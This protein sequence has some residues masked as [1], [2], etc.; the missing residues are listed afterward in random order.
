MRFC[1]ANPCFTRK[2]A[3]LAA[4]V[5]LSILL[6]SIPADAA[7]VSGVPAARTQRVGDH[8]AYVAVASG[9]SPT[10]WQWQLDGTNLPG[11]TASSLSLTNI[12]L[13]N[14]GTYTV[15]ATVTGG[16]DTATATLVVSNGYLPL[17]STNLVVARLGDGAQA[18]NTTT[19]NT[20][21]L[22]Q[23]Q[24]NGAYVS[25]VMVP[26]SGAS[27]MI[28]EGSGSAGLDGT[29]L[30]LSTNG[31]YLN[32]TGYNQALPNSG[33]TFTGENIPRAIGAVNGWGYYTL[34]L[35]NFG[36]YRRRERTDSLR[37]FDR[38]H[39]QY[40]LDGR[41]GLFRQW[42]HQDADLQPGRQRHPRRWRRQRSARA[43]HLP[44]QSL[45]VQRK[46]RRGPVPGALFVQRF[47][48]RLTDR[49]R[50][51]A[52]SHRRFQRSR[53]L[54]LQPGRPDGLYCGRR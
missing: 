11:Q 44:G 18:L 22:D 21:Y 40:F 30:T 24:T 32:F 2:A 19:G 38:R 50:H 17:A 4:S 16:P 28:A 9:V 47:A 8:L 10:A 20:I 5:S 15:V 33:V 31:E 23:I 43:Q 12:Q 53:R 48:Q 36:L 45:G 54:R 25:T 3:V 7:P 49:Q 6:D 37:G 29:V 26:D 41:R 39:C 35:T 27:A 1:A 46:Q 42:Q 51:P 13:T 14:A 52:N 34:C